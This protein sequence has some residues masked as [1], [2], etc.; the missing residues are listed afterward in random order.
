M[1]DWLCARF[2]KKHYVL[3]S[4][5]AG[6][7]IDNCKVFRAWAKVSRAIS[8]CERI[9]V[10]GKHY[11]FEENDHKVSTTS[12]EIKGMFPD[13]KP[14][15]Y[16]MVEDHNSTI[17]IDAVIGYALAFWRMVFVS[18]GLATDDQVKYPMPPRRVT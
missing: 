8:M 3:L 14:L 7:H 17:P 9:S 16:L 12:K 1:A 4:S 18:T 13:G 5:H 10:A 15:N 11:H 2:E 6:R